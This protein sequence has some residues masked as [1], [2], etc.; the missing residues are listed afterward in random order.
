MVMSRQP[1]IKHDVSLI[2]FLKGYAIFTIVL[3]HLLQNVGLPTYVEQGLAFGGTG[4]HTFFLLS[5]FGLYLSHLRRP[6]S[7]RAFV[8]KR[9]AKIYVPYLGV[10]LLSALLSLFLPVFASSGYALLG[11]VF[12]YKMFD[13]QIIGSYGYH[14]WF[15]S[16]IIQFYL[17]FPAFAWL[18]QRTS[19]TTFL[20]TTLAL[21]ALWIGVV[22]A[23]GKGEV[24]AWYSFFLQYAWEFGLGMLLAQR[25]AQRGAWKLPSGW[26]LSGCAL[27]GLTIYSL[28]TLYGGTV[29][30]MTNDLPALVGYTAVGLLVYRLRWTVVRRFLLFTG[31][32]SYA[33][34]LVHI[35]VKL[36]IKHGLQ[37]YGWPLNAPALLFILLAMYGVA[38]GYHRGVIAR[39]PY[40][41]LTQRLSLKSIG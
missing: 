14:L 41:L 17:A 8:G 3:F 18:K 19:D 40:H 30:K 31:T 15:V 2:T 21:S 13:D 4:V 16:T 5:G 25:Y 34:Y 28:M 24:R 38:Y 6:L 10:V 39:T 9:F 1:E 27:V 12:L 37:Y 23:L 26:V 35:V 11:H 32:I 20:L 7:F 36:T 29:G 22:L 33:L